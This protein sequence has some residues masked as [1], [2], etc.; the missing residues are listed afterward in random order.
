MGG[1]HER[2][3]RWFSAV[4]VVIAGLCLWSLAA[5]AETQLSV[6]GGANWNFSSDVKLRGV[7]NVADEQRSVDWDGGSFDMPPYWGVRGVY[8]LSKSSNW[9]FAVDYT[10]QKALANINFANDATF[11]RLE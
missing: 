5:V 8:W 10:H 7:P 9:G 2:M 4:G 3:R 1:G 6:Y 11:N